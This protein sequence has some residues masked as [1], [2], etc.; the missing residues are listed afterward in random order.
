[1]LRRFEAEEGFSLLEL[2]MVVAIIGVLVGIA[3]VSYAISVRS[4]KETACRANLRIIEG[5][6]L[7]YQDRYGESSPSLTDLVP[8]FIESSDS[9]RC[10]E[11]GEPYDYDHAS[12]AVSCP[13]HSAP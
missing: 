5:Q 11:T 8:E 9:L 13:Y 3:V 10:P 6:V 12:G 2:M 1:M 4:S 7:Q